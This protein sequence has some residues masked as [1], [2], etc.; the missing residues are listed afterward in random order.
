MQPTFEKL[1]C[2]LEYIF[3]LSHMM[4]NFGLIPMGVQIKPQI[5]DLTR[6]IIGKDYI[7]SSFGSL[8]I[9]NYT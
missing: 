4:I 5:L 6:K 1:S 3:G 2:F 7:I 8:M 9:L